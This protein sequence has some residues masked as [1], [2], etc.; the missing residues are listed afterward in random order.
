M[1]KNPSAKAYPSKMSVNDKKLDGWK[2][3]KVAFLKSLRH[4]MKAYLAGQLPIL[5]MMIQ[6]KVMKNII[7]KHKNVPL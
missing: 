6:L 5:E 1:K 7:L 2:Q 4:F 3:F